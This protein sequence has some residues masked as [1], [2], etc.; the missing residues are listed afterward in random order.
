MYQLGESWDL[1]ATWVY[2]TGQ[3]YTVPTGQYIRV[4]PEYPY[5]LDDEYL[6]YSTDYRYT[7]RNEYRIPSY[8]RL[9]VNF[10][11]TFT[12]FDLPW[13][14]SLNVYNVY[15]RRNVFSW[16]ITQDYDD[17]TG[18]YGPVVKQLTLFPVIPTVG[19]SFEF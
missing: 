8:H 12:W 9:D 6:S 16:Y 7:T 19:V 10:G 17:E 15:N 2:G 3:A 5:Y 1:G 18:E 11:H 14:L 13:R 4:D